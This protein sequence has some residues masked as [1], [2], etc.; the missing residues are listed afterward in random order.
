M[1]HKCSGQ[2]E[3]KNQGTRRL[4]LPLALAPALDS[5]LNRVLLSLTILLLSAAYSETGRYFN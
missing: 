2:K 1:A 4:A 5:E 3:L